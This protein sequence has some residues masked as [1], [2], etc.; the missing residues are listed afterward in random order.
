M[1]NISEPHYVI[2]LDPDT[3]PHGIALSTPPLIEN[4]L[5]GQLLGQT[6]QKALG[7]RAFF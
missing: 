7:N 5:S 4:D 2:S 6:N 1:L 3:P